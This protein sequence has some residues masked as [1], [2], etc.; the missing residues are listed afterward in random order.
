MGAAALIEPRASSDHLLLAITA[1][2]LVLSVPTGVT[3]GHWG[4]LVVTTAV[5]LTVVIDLKRSGT[6]RSGFCKFGKYW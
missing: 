5:V 1:T 2:V 4:C 3:T 6:Y